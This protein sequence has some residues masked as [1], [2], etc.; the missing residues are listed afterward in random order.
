MA[1]EIAAHLTT[2]E[3]EAGL[4]AIL[5]APA[6]EGVVQLIV[7][8]PAENEREVLEEG[9]LDHVAGSRRRHVAHRAAA[10]AQPT[11]P[12]TRTCS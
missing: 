5:R 10:S 8:R 1:T 4:D 2:E 12:R 9:E 11:A 6:S 3:L 7:R